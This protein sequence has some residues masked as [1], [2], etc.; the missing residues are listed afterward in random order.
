MRKALLWIVRFGDDTKNGGGF[1]YPTLDD[2][3]SGAICQMEPDPKRWRQLK[4]GG[5]YRAVRVLVKE[6][7]EPK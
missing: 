2:T 7:K 5:D 6:L 3:R 4:R 1:V